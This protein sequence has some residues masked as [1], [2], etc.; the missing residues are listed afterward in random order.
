MFLF[1]AKIFKKR[2]YNIRHPLTAPLPHAT[3]VKGWRV[4]GVEKWCFLMPFEWTRRGR[5]ASLLCRHGGTEDGRPG[6]ATAFLVWFRPPTRGAEEV[7]I[8][9]MCSLLQ[10][11]IFFFLSLQYQKW[12]KKHIDNIRHPWAAERSEAT[13]VLNSFW[14][15]WL[16]LFFFLSLQ[17]QKWGKKLHW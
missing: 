11:T 9:Q 4:R 12:G 13:S 7:D 6:F 5:F 15:C 2:I 8:T 16:V 17:Y 1:A 14:F 3:S 10:R